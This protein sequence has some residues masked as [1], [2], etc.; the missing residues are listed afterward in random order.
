[1]ST[2]LTFKAFE[3]WQWFQDKLLLK[4]PIRW[5]N[6]SKKLVYSKFTTKFV[7]W[8]LAGGVVLPITLFYCICLLWLNI[9]D[10]IRLTPLHAGL[11]VVV[12]LIFNFTFSAEIGI[13]FAGAELVLGYNRFLEFEKYIYSGKIYFAF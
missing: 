5:C 8:Y 13:Y 3:T 6:K 11:I 9:I 12:V 10:I 2:E 4:F 7:P 1:M